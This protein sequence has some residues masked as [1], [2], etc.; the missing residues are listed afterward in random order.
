MLLLFPWLNNNDND[1][2]K[3]LLVSNRKGTLLITFS[4]Y[5]NR[6]E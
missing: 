2:I 3:N 4:M 5:T 6:Y 1:A